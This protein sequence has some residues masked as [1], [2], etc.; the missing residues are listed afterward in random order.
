MLSLKAAESDS[1]GFAV[2]YAYFEKHS[3]INQLI[4]PLLLFLDNN[5][6]EYPPGSGQ[7]ELLKPHSGSSGGGPS[8][9]PAHRM[10]FTSSYLWRLP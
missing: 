9:P 5:S 6:P 10:A 1:T 3:R 4:A 8:L 2:F 7:P